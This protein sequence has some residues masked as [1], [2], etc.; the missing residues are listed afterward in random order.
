MVIT[1]SED[2]NFTKQCSIQSIIELFDC[3]LCTFC[4][5]SISKIATPSGEAVESITCG[6]E[7]SFTS[8]DAS[9]SIIGNNATKPIDFKAGGSDGCP[10]TYIIKPVQCDKETGDCVIVPK[11]ET[12]F[13]SSDCFFADYAP[14][15]IKDFNQITNINRSMTSNYDNEFIVERGLARGVDFLLKYKTKKLY[16]WSVYSLGFIKRYWKSNTIFRNV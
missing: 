6:E 16:L 13:Y 10:T 9:V 7:I 4:T 3:D 11:Q 14:G 5:T 15:Y 2:K 8:S 12:W 1:D